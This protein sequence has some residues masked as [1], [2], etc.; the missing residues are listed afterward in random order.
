MVME[1]SPVLK[2]AVCPPSSTHNSLADAN[3][4]PN[5]PLTAA[6]FNVAANAPTEH[7]HPAPPYQPSW[8]CRAPE[9]LPPA[10]PWKHGRAPATITHW[11]LSDGFAS[12]AVAFSNGAEI[13]LCLSFYNKEVI[14]TVEA[15]LEGGSHG[16]HEGETGGK[17]EGGQRPSWRSDGRMERSM[18]AVCSYRRQHA[19]GKA[20]T[21]NGDPALLNGGDGVAEQCSA[22]CNNICETAA[23]SSDGSTSVPRSLEGSDVDLAPA[24]CD[25]MPAGT[26]HSV[27]SE[28][29]C[30]ALA[31]SAEICSVLSNPKGDS[32]AST[33]TRSVHCNGV[34]GGSAGIS[35][36]TASPVE[37]AASDPNSSR[38]DEEDS[39]AVLDS[40]S[41]THAA[42]T[43]LSVVNL[44]CL[45]NNG[46]AGTQQ[47][48]AGSGHEMATGDHGSGTAL[49]AATEPSAAA[50]SN[51]SA[52]AST[53]TAS[54]E[55][56]ALRKHVAQ[57]KQDAAVLREHLAGLESRE[58]ESAVP[59]DAHAASCC[60]GQQSAAFRAA[61][62]AI[63]KL[64]QQL[65][66]GAAD[67]TSK[68]ALLTSAL[69]DGCSGSNSTVCGEDKCTIN[70]EHC[71]RGARTAVRDSGHALEASRRS[72]QAS[73][74][75]RGEKRLLLVAVLQLASAWLSKR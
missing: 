5:H 32:G 28:D 10:P 16:P 36:D 63:V 64:C 33:V 8:A 15:L 56:R 50:G 53:H 60:S 59:A 17:R 6:A 43:A 26:T 30:A 41:E 38:P 68:V 62:Q 46:D 39:P 44:I 37:T 72:R 45:S 54:K 73:R 1:Q 52:G 61:L 23:L 70:S 47:A 58:K 25:V 19:S 7:T 49:T 74:R 4:Q 21:G 11:S 27:C 18:N 51:S 24:P 35:I 66:T 14:C 29:I 34:G 13:L 69:A 22:S 2:S 42:P 67:S 55:E 31:V 75:L 9:A 40:S 3:A 48:A 57:L 65:L 20:G 71:S 12:G